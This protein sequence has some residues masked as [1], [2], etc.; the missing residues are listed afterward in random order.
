MTQQKSCAEGRDSNPHA[1]KA[2]DFKSPAFAISP[3]RQVARVTRSKAMYTGF[4]TQ[5]D[6]SSTTR[7]KK[8]ES[9]HGERRAHQRGSR[10]LKDVAKARF[11]GG[12]YSKLSRARWLADGY[13]RRC[14]MQGGSS[15]AACCAWWAKSTQASTAPRL[16]ALSARGWFRVCESGSRTLPMLSGRSRACAASPD[17]APLLVVDLAIRFLLSTNDLGPRDCAPLRRPC[18]RRSR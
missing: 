1:D 11:E 8:I 14:S 4:L 2:G 15:S 5:I 7:S 10:L 3:P 13:W 18:H 9:R 6:G 12:A 17:P 16:G